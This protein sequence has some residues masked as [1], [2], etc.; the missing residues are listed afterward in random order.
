MTALRFMTS[1]PKGEETPPQ[2]ETENAAKRVASAAQELFRG[3]EAHPVWERPILLLL[4]TS[5]MVL[6]V[7]NIGING[8]ANS[9][10]SAAVQAG[11][12]DWKAFFFGSSDWGNSITVDKPPLS[13][14]VMG[15]SARVFGLSPESILIPQ[16]IIGVATTLLIYV[17]VR[18]HFSTF[19]ALAAALAFFITPIVT[20]LCRY[21]NPD[22]LMLLL[23]VGSVYFVVRAVESGTAG[24]FALAG[25]LLGL[26]FMTKQLQ[27]LTN[28]PALVLAFLVS[29]TCLLGRKFQAC[30]FGAVA[31]VIT[32]GFWM[33]AVDLI[34][35][36]ARPYVGGSTNNSALQLT[37]AYNGLNRLFPTQKDPTV[38]LI[39]ETFKSAES[40][41]GLLR[42]LNSNFSQE[43]GWLLAVGLL[44]CLWLLLAWRSVATSP[45]RRATALISLIW[46]LTTYLMLS[47]MGDG[48]HTYYTAT[49]VPPLAL[50]IAM[51]IESLTTMKFRTAARLLASVTV[52]AGALVQWVLLNG[53]EGWHPAFVMAVLGSGLTGAALLAVRPPAKWIN[54]V[55]CGLAAAALV[56]GPAATSIYTTTVVHQG[57][58][59][60][61]GPI[62]KS[63]TS[64]SR[65]LESVKKKETGWAYDV[66]FGFDPS[67]ELVAR[68]MDTPA[69][70][71]GAATYPSQSAAKL[72]LASSK[73][74]LPLGGFSG[75][76]PAP[77]LEQF[78]GL[79]REGKVCML[80]WHQDHLELPG[81]SPD[82]LDISRW[83]SS[84]FRPVQVGDVTVYD[85]KAQR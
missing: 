53:V 2:P 17:I 3:P 52:L 30:F 71:W 34:P 73:A 36:A 67:P 84:E 42:L 80:V 13:L 6:Y 68:T 66:G 21:N 39:P 5:N 23:M 77:T 29:A 57:S 44:S 50:M 72:Q 20:L 32:G 7:V 41:A 24:P 58:N 11:T 37:L 10:Y 79:V 14:W 31:L 40:D 74:V 47:F 9:F 1:A 55:A 78:Q 65:F 28:V 85:L 81:R 25:A 43:A 35:P 54:I 15:I 76:D 63:N 4:L 45:A 64:I 61:S 8:W 83:V 49:L 60:V 82:L 27:A 69:C 59:P 26:A 38:D 33:A 46:F 62:T 19:A 56:A 70:T 12:M 16:A 48:I 51:G 22:P 75:T 18:R